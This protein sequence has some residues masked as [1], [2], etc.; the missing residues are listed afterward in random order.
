LNISDLFFQRYDALYSFWP[1]D[2]WERVSPEQ[3][4]Q[5]PHPQVNSIAWNLWRLAR[6]EDAGVNPL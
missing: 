6:V 4:R 1:G 3:M 5:R 2:I